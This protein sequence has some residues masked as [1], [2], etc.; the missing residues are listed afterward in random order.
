MTKTKR[1]ITENVEKNNVEKAKWYKNGSDPNVTLLGNDISK[2]LVLIV[3]F[4]T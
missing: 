4:K 1:K 2:D 3:R